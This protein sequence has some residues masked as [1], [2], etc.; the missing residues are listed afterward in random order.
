M[1]SIAH[2]ELLPHL[3]LTSECQTSLRVGRW[4]L[5]DGAAGQRTGAKLLGGTSVL[6]APAC[7]RT[8]PFGDIPEVSPEKNTKGILWSFLH[9]IF[10]QATWILLRWD[11]VYPNK[12]SCTFQYVTQSNQMFQLQCISWFLKNDRGKVLQW[13]LRSVCLVIYYIFPNQINVVWTL[14]WKDRRYLTDTCWWTNCIRISGSSLSLLLTKWQ[15]KIG[16]F[17]FLYK[18]AVLQAKTFPLNVKTFLL[19]LNSF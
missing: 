10:F 4:V 18:I 8:L 1:L 11:L 19:N 13:T 7:P 9:C 5:G 2:T 3:R 15:K 6:W 16:F 17:F 12:N 14:L